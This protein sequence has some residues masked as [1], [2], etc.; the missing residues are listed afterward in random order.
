MR[1]LL[2]ILILPLLTNAQESINVSFKGGLTTSFYSTFKPV[3]T[4]KSYFI[5]ASFTKQLNNFQGGIEVSNTSIGFTALWDFNNLY[6][7]KSSNTRL[8][9][10][11]CYNYIADFETLD[12]LAITSGKHIFICPYVEQRLKVFKWCYLYAQGRA[13]SLDG[14][15]FYLGTEI[16]L[17][18]Q[19]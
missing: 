15:S 5:A 10:N 8:G 7:P 17:S 4:P 19:N 9:L 2:F 18:F 3:N 13:Q 1:L 12:G 14:F 11:I 6:K 16:I